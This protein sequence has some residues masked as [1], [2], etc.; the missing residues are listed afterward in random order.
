MPASS[1]RD[2]TQNGSE[3]LGLRSEPTRRIQPIAVTAS[4]GCSTPVMRILKIELP[5]TL[6]SSDP[7]VSLASDLLREQLHR[8]LEA[9]RLELAEDVRRRAA[10]YFPPDYTIFVRF[11][12]RVEDNRAAVILWIDDPTVRWPGGLFARRAWRLSVPIVAHIVNE[13]FEERIKSIRM[14]IHEKKARVVSL[15]PLRGWLDP[16]IL[17]VIVTLTSAGYWLLVHPW[18]W[19]W[20][21]GGKH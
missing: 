5:A 21:T 4:T 11:F 7:D 15:A 6:T 1:R 17:S 9:L 12:F 8:E 2:G 13:S 3:R 20:L 10:S 19:A 14:D 16:V 18:I